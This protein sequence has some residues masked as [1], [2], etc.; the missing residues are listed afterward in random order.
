MVGDT[1]SEMCAFTGHRP[2]LSVPVEQDDIFCGLDTSGR[3]FSVN[4]YLPWFPG[5]PV[6]GKIEQWVQEKKQ[7]KQKERPPLLSLF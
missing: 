6:S 1:A 3:G 5:N 2:T 7:S 4:L